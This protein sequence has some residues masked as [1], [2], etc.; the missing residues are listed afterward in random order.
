MKV[1]SQDSARDGD[2]AKAAAQ[3]TRLRS[4]ARSKSI[5]VRLKAKWDYT[6]DARRCAKAT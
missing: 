6:R 1:F 5:A 3:R 4:H 2:N